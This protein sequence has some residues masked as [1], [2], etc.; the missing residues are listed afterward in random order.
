MSLEL[1]AIIFL[2]G[3]FIIGS[4]FPVNIGVLGFVAAFVIG[5]LVSG[6]ET[7]AVLGVFPA[8]LFVLL[9]GI[10]FMFSIVQKN[11]TIDLIASWGLKLVRGNLGL[12]PW[13][14]FFLG[15]ALAALGTSVVAL[16]SIL[17]PLVL[18][19]AYK[20][21]INALMMG[22]LLIV[23]LTAGAFSP[24]NLFGLIVKGVLESRGLPHEP[25]I[26]MVNVLLFCFVVGLIV[27]VVLGGIKNFKLSSKNV[28]DAQL[29]TAAAYASDEE[30]EEEENIFDNVKLDW[31]KAATLIGIG[32]LIYMALFLEFHM[33][34]S[35]FTIG[36]ILAF[37]RPSLQTEVVKAIPWPV[38]LMVTGIV[39]Y[40]GVLDAIGSIDYMTDLISGLNNSYVASLVASYTGGIISSF[41]STT[42]FLA[43]IIPLVTPILEDPT[44]SST[45]VVAAIA[46]SSSIVDL[47]PFSTNGALLL[48]NCKPSEE[49]SFFRKLLV[50]SG[51]F[52]VIGPLAAWLLFVVVGVP[53]G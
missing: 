47:S 23:G 42:G 48:S 33:G 40:V 31:Y 18:R 10:T 51:I 16:A 13:V 35:A 25:V 43:A 20:F 6:M 29:R 26:L 4:I 17:A 1:F 8:D 7:K 44:I 50:M 28:S 22:T 46:I 53:W 27:F 49:R 36:L 45:G 52:I 5:V 2:V 32:V 38:I 15:T 14:V 41:A 24:L 34:F 11:G 12:I 30:F 39:T 19:L 9:T 37:M 3:M 21:K